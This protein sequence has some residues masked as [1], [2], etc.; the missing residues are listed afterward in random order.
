[1]GKSL[2]GMPTIAETD[3]ILT[4]SFLSFWLRLFVFLESPQSDLVNIFFINNNRK[5][6]M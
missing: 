4:P 1:M 3:R 6:S 2:G 5:T